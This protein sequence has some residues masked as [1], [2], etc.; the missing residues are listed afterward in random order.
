VNPPRG[1]RA[2]KT[3]PRLRRAAAAAREVLIDLAAA[4]WT[5]DRRELVVADGKVTHPSS[6]R[7]SGYGPLSKGQKIAEAI[8]D[9]LPTTPADQWK[10]EGQPVPKVDGRNFVTGRHK[11]VSDMK[12]PGMLCGK[13]LR[14]VAFGA[15][16]DSADTKEAARIPGVIVVHD[17]NFVGVAAPN[18]SGARQAVAAIQAEWKPNPSPQGKK[19]SIT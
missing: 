7:S 9:D 3:V 19:S 12:L 14:P 2:C 4:A 13:V 18:E 8:P 11:Y 16:L 5:V 10:I 6:K 15:T 17:G 1:W